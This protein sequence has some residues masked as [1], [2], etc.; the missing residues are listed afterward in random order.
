MTHFAREYGGALFALAGKE[1]LTDRIMDELN[2]LSQ[3]L[4]ENPKYLRLLATRSMDGAM[5]KQ[6]LDE[7]LR[8]RI[9]DYLLNF[10]K[11]L[12]D[13]GA[14]SNVGECIDAYTEMYNEM[15]GIEKASVVSATELTEEEKDAVRTKLEHMTG[16]TMR[17]TYSVDPAL[18]GGLCVDVAGRRYDNT[19]RARLA[20]L[21][22]TLVRG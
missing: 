11:L 6:L 16:K 3:L 19:I 1:N 10:L 14:V 8:G 7:A 17:V 2:M 4:A 12:I 13:R 18:I 5:R 9:H 21:K 20:D 22:Q 15:Y